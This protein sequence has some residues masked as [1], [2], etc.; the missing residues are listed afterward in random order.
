MD[1]AKA[2]FQAQGLDVST[3]PIVSNP[4]AIAGLT[5][6]SVTFFSCPNVTVFTAFTSGIPIRAVVAFVASK[7]GLA[8]E[9]TLADSGI[10]TGK[11]INGKTYGETALNSSGELNIKAWI[12]NR[13][14]DP[15]TVHFIAVP[16]S[17]MA[18]LLLQHRI[19]VAAM[20]EPFVTPI[21]HDSRFRILGNSIPAVVP[22]GTNLGSWCA[23]SSWLAAN[24]DVAKRFA[25][26]MIKANLY[27]SEHPAEAKK[28]LPALTGVTA[29][30]AQATKIGSYPTYFDLCTYQK[31]ADYAYQY[32]LIPQKIDVRNTLWSG[33][34]VSTTRKKC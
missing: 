14:G 15:T 2:Q 16:N 22:F 27:A 21:L 25:T 29:A 9:V 23:S 18:S 8:A 34:V 28:A 6:G 12:K 5:T 11:D 26:A 1:Y 24:P 10:R 30:Q 19:D 3:V 17:D 20:N 33:A 13:G 31:Q 4:T 32:G 7:P